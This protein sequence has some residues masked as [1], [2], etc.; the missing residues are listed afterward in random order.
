MGVLTQWMEQVWNRQNPG[1]IDELMEPN[2]NA[3]S[4]Q[5]VIEGTA[6]FR[7]WYD[8]WTG[9]LDEIHIEVEQEIEAADFTAVRVTISGKHKRTGA[10]VSFPAAVFARVA[11]GKIQE[12]WDVLDSGAML[13]TM[14]VLGPSAVANTI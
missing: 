7:A 8:Q 14:G 9:V 5:G 6:G 10:A 12:S 13:T 2:A 4:I 1:A 11:D 3:H